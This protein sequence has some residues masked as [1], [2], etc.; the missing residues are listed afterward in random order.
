MKKFLFFALALSMVNMYG[1]DIKADEHS[2]HSHRYALSESK[3]KKHH[4]HYLSAVGPTKP[5]TS[6]PSNEDI[7]AI[8]FNT[9]VVKSY[10]FEHPVHGDN[11][12]FEVEHSGIYLIGYDFSLYPFLDIGQSL[13]IVSSILVNG[14]QEDIRGRAS[15]MFI[16]LITDQ[17][18]RPVSNTT[19]IKLKRGDILQLVIN[20]QPGGIN[21]NVAFPTI[22]ITQIDRS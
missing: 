8:G 1:N 13:R 11:T 7:I 4:V 22:F 21:F 15:L 14:D 20:S 9:N 10:G 16:D 12:K 17:S 5:F 18:T 19:I 3:E 6:P 2:G